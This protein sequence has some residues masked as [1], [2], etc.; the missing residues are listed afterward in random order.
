[1]TAREVSVVGVGGGGCRIVDALSELVHEGPSLVAVNTDTRSLETTRATTKVQIGRS[2]TDGLGAGGHVSLGRLAAQDDLAVLQGLFAD[3]KLALGVV[4][5]G[6]GTGTGAVPVLLRAAREA[7]AMT[8]CFATLPFTFEGE[9]RRQLAQDACDEIRETSD[10]FIVIPNDRLFHT[11]DDV[12]VADA[13]DRADRVVAGGLCAVWKLLT[14]PGYIS[15]DFS[16]LKRV[17]R[18]AGRACSFGYAEASGEG[19]AT[20]VV[21]QL[22]QSSL[23]A[24]G[25]HVANAGAILAS[26]VGGPDLTLREVGEIMGALQSKISKDCRMEM[27]TVVDDGWDGKVTV[28][29]IVSEDAPPQDVPESMATELPGIA[30]V[31]PAPGK[32]G[33]KKKRQRQTSLSFGATGKGRFKDVEPTIMDGEDLDIPTFVRRGIRL[34]E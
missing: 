34:P 13:F 29:L 18:C 24:H 9:Q 23:L 5:W 11:G 20:R 4:G 15:L 25:Q 1:M 27:G 17:A 21:E 14:D 7:G 6:G 10:A 22:L 28:S 32:R 12:R 8:L 30:S 19:R 3:V 2:H 16:D 31:E 33:G 26:I